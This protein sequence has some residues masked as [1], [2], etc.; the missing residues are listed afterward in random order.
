MKGIEDIRREPE[1]ERWL[2]N[3]LLRIRDKDGHFFTAE[4]VSQTDDTWCQVR[5][6]GGDMRLRDVKL[7]KDL[8]AQRREDEKAA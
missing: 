1:Q 7:P 2:P 4:F 3:C 8:I 6:T 5:P